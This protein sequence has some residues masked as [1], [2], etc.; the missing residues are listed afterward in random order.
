M[1]VKEYLSGIEQAK[2]TLTAPDGKTFAD[3]MAESAELWS[4][5]ACKGYFLQAALVAGIDQSVIKEILRAYKEVFETLTVDEAAATY[6]RYGA[7]KQ[8]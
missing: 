3:A 2:L 8:E 6:C 5:D 1:T 4:N 7:V